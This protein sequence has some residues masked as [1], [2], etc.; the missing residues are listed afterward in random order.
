MAVARAVLS[1]ISRFVSAM[2]MLNF[3]GQQKVSTSVQNFVRMTLRK[4]SFVCSIPPRLQVLRPPIQPNHRLLNPRA[5]TDPG[6]CHD[7]ARR[8]PGSQTPVPKRWT[9]RRW[10]I[11]SA[12]MCGCSASSAACRGWSCRSGRCVLACMARQQP[13]RPQ[14]MRIAVVLGLVASQ[15]HQPSPGLDDALRHSSIAATRSP[16]PCRARSTLAASR[17]P[18][19]SF[20]KPAPEAR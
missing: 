17:Y 6:G 13:R 4:R 3:G 1:A 10:R 5:R 11:G 16:V 15:R 20:G 19:G 9:A 8:N 18:C 7:L 12:R 14:L 2:A